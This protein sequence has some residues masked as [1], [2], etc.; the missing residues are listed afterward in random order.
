M[1]VIHKLNPN[2]GGQQTPKRLIIHSMSE[3]INGVHAS[4]F[5]DHIGLSA[6]FL[7]EPNGNLIKDT[8]GI[9]VLV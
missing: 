6:H 7:I 8:I 5:L 9:E 1:E 4:D 2:G 3:Y